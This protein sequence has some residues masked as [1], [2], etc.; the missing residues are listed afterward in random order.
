MKT[1]DRTEYD[2]KNI[3]YLRRLARRR[4]KV[5]SVHLILSAAALMITFGGV[6]K[7]VNG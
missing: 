3:Q 5:T 6:M 2:R 1:D 7:I 4:A